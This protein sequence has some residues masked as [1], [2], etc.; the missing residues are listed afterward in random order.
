[1]GCRVTSSQCHILESRSSMSHGVHRHIRQGYRSLEPNFQHTVVL[2]DIQRKNPLLYDTASHHASLRSLH[3]HLRYMSVYAYPSETSILSLAA[4]LVC[5]PY[6]A[7][8][9]A[10]VCD[11][12]QGSRTLSDIQLC[13]VL[14]CSGF[15]AV[16]DEDIRASM[17][18]LRCLIMT[19]LSG[20]RSEY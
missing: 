7:T 19:S 16:Y 6:S 20:H 12:S 10:A 8:A 15:C 11:C 14:V 5:T 3:R 17:R 9:S 4:Q 1:M 18:E 2:G 13:H